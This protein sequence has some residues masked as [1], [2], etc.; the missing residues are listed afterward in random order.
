MRNSSGRH[1]SKISFWDK[2]LFMNLAV[3][4]EFY[5][6]ME[7]E[8]AGGGNVNKGLEQFIDELEGLFSA[9]RQKNFRIVQERLVNGDILSVATTGFFPSEDRLFLKALEDNQDKSSGFNLLASR[10][11]RAQS[12]RMATVVAF[13]PSLIVL[14]VAIFV[15]HFAGQTLDDAVNRSRTVNELNGLAGIAAAFSRF[16]YPIV[17]ACATIPIWVVMLIGWSFSNWTGA[18]RRLFDN[19]GPW[20][21]YREATG[22]ALLLNLSDMFNSGIGIKE[23]VTSMS[24]DASPWL[25]RILNTAYE[26]VVGGDLLGTALLSTGTALPTRSIL[27][28]LK[29]IEQAD[30]FA[31]KL[32]SLVTAYGEQN[33]AHTSAKIA[34][35]AFVSMMVGLLVIAMSA[36]L[37]FGI[38]RI[39]RADLASNIF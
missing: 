32:R 34:F 15:F 27:T 19:I 8:F 9:R 36:I 13:A 30:G 25:K 12:G 24:E 26:G 31:E 28:K 23:A 11:E 6:N 22:A 21:T 18:A 3:R 4:A 38:G 16:S 2:H 37:M 14:A 5:R 35:Y 29:L 20:K 7:Y 1:Q 33:A 10:A 39:T 17:I